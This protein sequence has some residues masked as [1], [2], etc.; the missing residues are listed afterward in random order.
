MNRRASH[1]Q[2][3]WRTGGGS[4][5]GGGQ[6]RDGRPLRFARV[7]GPVFAAT[8][9]DRPAPA[10]AALTSTPTHSPPPPRPTE[11]GEQPFQGSKGFHPLGTPYRLAGEAPLG[12]LDAPSSPLAPLLLSTER[13][14]GHGSRDGHARQ[15]KQR[16]Q[17]AKQRQGEMARKT[18]TYFLRF[19]PTGTRS[20]VTVRE[21][22]TPR[23]ARILATVIIAFKQG[24]QEQ[25][26]DLP[27]H[28]S[29]AEMRYGDVFLL[30][31]NARAV[32]MFLARLALGP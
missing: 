1:K 14:S 31:R 8:R 19:G 24:L 20:L 11:G 10:F 9:L 30:S 13:G 23:Q 5:S 32:A 29:E 17:G 21:R 4:G 22:Y 27:E 15:L 25:G 6:G 26:D 2:G 28:A 3:P 12:H 18:K 7:R 16:R